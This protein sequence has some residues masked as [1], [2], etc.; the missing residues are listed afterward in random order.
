MTKKEVLDIGIDISVLLDY[1]LDEYTD[2]S[3]VAN[4][5]IIFLVSVLKK[6]PELRKF[7]AEIYNDDFDKQVAWIKFEDKMFT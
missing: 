6:H 3:D 2:S 7:V 4:S 5:A 1:I